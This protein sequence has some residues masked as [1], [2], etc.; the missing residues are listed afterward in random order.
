[1]FKA[2]RDLS[3]LD[4]FNFVIGPVTKN[5]G[6]GYE[7]VGRPLAARVLLSPAGAHTGLCEHP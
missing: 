5:H 1:M 2:G 7:S 6:R 4:V 3:R